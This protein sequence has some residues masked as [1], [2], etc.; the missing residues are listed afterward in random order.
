MIQPQRVPV[1]VG[2]ELHL[3]DQDYRYGFGP[4]R[5]R[6]TAVGERLQLP[7]G[8]WA[9]VRGVTLTSTGEEIAEREALVRLDTVGIWLRR[10]PAS[11]TT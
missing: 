2:D 11:G 3:R 9:R 7:D 8:P 5:L 6:V 1:Q 4:M 10:K